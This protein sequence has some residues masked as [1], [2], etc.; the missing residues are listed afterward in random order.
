MRVVWQSEIDPY[1]C[2]VLAKHWP[3]VTNHGDVRSLRGDSLEPVDLICGG[4]P[5]QPYSAAGKGL[6]EKD[7]R[8]MWPEFARVVRETR[9]RWI[10]AENVFAFRTRGLDRAAHDLEAHG[11]SVWPFAVGA[12]DLGA[13]HRRKRLWI[14][15]YADPQRCEFIGLKE[16]G[17]QQSAFRRELDGLGN[18]RLWPGA[19]DSDSIAPRLPRSEY[20]REFGARGGLEGRAVAELH[21][22]S[23]WAWECAPEP[24]FRGMDAGLPHELDENRR[25][26]LAALGNA[27]LPQ[28]AEAIGRAILRVEAEI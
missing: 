18:G 5:C 24:V 4:F 11:Y 27:L 7:P 10:V 28:I 26:R 21:G 12:S 8:D 13:P 25:P 17:E 9:P 3:H 6:A 15:A 23:P 22:A 14:V 19:A 1:C 16:Y 20:A 2:A